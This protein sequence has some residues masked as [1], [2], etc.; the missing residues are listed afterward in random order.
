M[1]SGDELCV[2][3]HSYEEH[4]PDLRCAAPECP[5][6]EFEPEDEAEDE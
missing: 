5:C 4:E 6:Q 1:P 3:G 2:C